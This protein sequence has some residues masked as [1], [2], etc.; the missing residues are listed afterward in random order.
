LAGQG[1][2]YALDK[3]AP[4]ITDPQQIENQKSMRDLATESRARLINALLGK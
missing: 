4:G 1:A 2:Q 3:Y